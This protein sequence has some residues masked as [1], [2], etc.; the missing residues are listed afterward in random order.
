MRNRISCKTS[1]LNSFFLK[2]LF[3]SEFVVATAHLSSGPNNYD[4][5]FKKFFFP[6]IT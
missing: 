1:D 6:L 3:Q 4:N 5:K 2:K